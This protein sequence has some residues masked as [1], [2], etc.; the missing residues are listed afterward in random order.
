MKYYA[1]FRYGV[2][3]YLSYGKGSQA[4]KDAEGYISRRGGL[5]AEIEASSRT[6]FFFKT[7]E[8][9]NENLKKPIQEL[10]SE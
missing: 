4:K 8:L 5:L 10:L 1:V 7:E 9:T 3:V 6:E 2:R